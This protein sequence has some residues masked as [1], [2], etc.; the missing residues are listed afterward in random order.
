MPHVVRSK[1]LSDLLHS[2][3]Q[4][5]NIHSGSKT[6][7]ERM[8][9][10]AAI[11]QSCDLLQHHFGAYCHDLIALMRSLGWALSSR[12][13]RLSAQAKM[14]RP[15][16]IRIPHVLRTSHLL[17]LLHGLGM[18]ETLAQSG[19]SHEVAPAHKCRQEGEEIGDVRRSDLNQKDSMSLVGTS[20][21][22]RDLIGA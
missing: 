11:Q 13:Y 4:S 9:E 8:I 1:V 16:T 15:P 21:R 17:E 14:T 3:L 7:I 22:Y 20:G 12:D 10:F 2:L 5:V 18:H 6:H 19:T